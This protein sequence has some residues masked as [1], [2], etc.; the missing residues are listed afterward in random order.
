MLTISLIT[1]FI[2]EIEQ[3]YFGFCFFTV[4]FRQKWPL[5]NP[6]TCLSEGRSLKVSL[7]VSRKELPDTWLSLI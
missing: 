5:T 2:L 6:Q 4:L 3:K 1:L 7:L